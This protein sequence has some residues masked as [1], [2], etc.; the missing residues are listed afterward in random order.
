MALTLPAMMLACVPFRADSLSSA[1]AMWGKLFDPSA[2]RWLGMRENVYLIATL[3]LVGIYATFFVKERVL[4]RLAG[5]PVIVLIGDI[6]TVAVVTALV[7]V[8]LR[9]INQFIYFQF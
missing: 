7:I 3:V 5:W 9:P 6:L 1:L 8:F 2:Y 4:P